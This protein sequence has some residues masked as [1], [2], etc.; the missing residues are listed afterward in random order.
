MSTLDRCTPRER[1]L[2]ELIIQYKKQYGFDPTYAEL[3]KRMD[4]SRVYVHDMVHSLQRKGAFD[5]RKQ[6]NKIFFLPAGAL[7]A[8]RKQIQEYAE[9]QQGQVINVKAEAEEAAHDIFGI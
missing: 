6:G 1:Q 8:K 5:L 9:K 7:E 3:S 2:L 4:L